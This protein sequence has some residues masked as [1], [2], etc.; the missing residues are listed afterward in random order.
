MPGFLRP[1]KLPVAAFLRVSE[2]DLDFEAISM[3]KAWPCWAVRAQW[4]QGRWYQRVWSGAKRP[5]LD[6]ALPFCPPP[7]HP[8]T[9]N[10][11][12]LRMLL[13]VS[14]SDGR[15]SEMEAGSFNSHPKGGGPTLL[16]RLFT[17]PT[18]KHLSNWLKP[19]P[20]VGTLLSLP[21]PPAPP[22][23]APGAVL[24]EEA[25]PRLSPGK[26]LVPRPPV[27]RVELADGIRASVWAP[28][29]FPRACKGPGPVPSASSYPVIPAGGHSRREPGPRARPP[30]EA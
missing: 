24:P 5:G 19:L 17:E 30:A 11:P 7:G 21:W 26:E 23:I 12:W 29:P 22:C 14:R 13:S 2:A 20:S 8:A 4:L 28:A 16:A 3:K 27:W 6:Q 10:P 1:T 25:E 15:P 9:P 18:S